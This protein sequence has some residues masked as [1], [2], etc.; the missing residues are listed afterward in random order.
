MDHGHHLSSW[1]VCECG[2]LERNNLDSWWPNLDWH[3]WHTD[4]FLERLSDARLQLQYVLWMHSLKLFLHDFILIICC[5][6]LACIYIYIYDIQ[7]Q[8]KLTKVY[9]FFG[10]SLCSFG[11]FD[12]ALRIRGNFAFPD[13]E[14]KLTWNIC[15]F[16]VNNLKGD[17]KTW[18]CHALSKF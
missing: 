2:C 7:M 1:S 8:P 3:I 14:E 17:R 4:H 6:Y 11:S 5:I 18:H 10:C 15:P 16:P 9:A 12:A 13:S